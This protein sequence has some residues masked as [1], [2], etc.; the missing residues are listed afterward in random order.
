[1]SSKPGTET[2]KVLRERTGAG[3]LDCKNALVETNG[4]VEDAIDYLRKKGLS[5]VSKRAGMLASEGLVGS[6]IHQ[7]GRIGVLLEVNCETDFVAKTEDFKNLV[8]DISMQI[9]ASNPLYVEREEIP[10]DV[11]ERERSIYRTQALE[12]GKPENFLD[13]IVEGKMKRFFSEVCLIE[14]PFVKDDKSSIRDF[15]NSYI[16]KLGENIKIRRFVR[17]EVGEGIETT[18][19]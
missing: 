14:Q 2:I 18:K 3:I 6:Y 12:S 4:N 19:V 5:T 9:A 15:V 17:Y 1:M 11:L 16:A 7:G 8:K 13:K 10:Q